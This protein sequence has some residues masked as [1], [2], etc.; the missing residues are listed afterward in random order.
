MKRKTV[1]GLL[2]GAALAAG[3]GGGDND[4][5]TDSLC[6][7][8]QAKLDECSTGLDVGA[9]CSIDSQPTQMVCA[10]RECVLPTRD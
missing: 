9:D 8:V 10:M 4:N 7:Q 2:A 3:C 6:S 5:G 1:P